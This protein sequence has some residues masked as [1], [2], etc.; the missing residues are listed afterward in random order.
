MKI[1]FKD[2]KERNY[3]AEL[4]NIQQRMGK[5]GHY[6][7]LSFTITEGELQNY[8]FSA[9]I[10]PNLIRNSKFHRWVSN[11]L[12]HDPDYEFYTHDLVGKHCIISLYKNK[13]LFVV[14]DV[15]VDTNTSFNNYF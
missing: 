12:G 14:S 13:N 2:I 6:L 7:Q 1:I 5:F 10:K 9:Y 4:S 11:L 8:T 15:L 3:R